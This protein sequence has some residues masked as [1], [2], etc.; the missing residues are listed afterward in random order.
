VCEIQFDLFHITNTVCVISWSLLYIL[1]DRP[2]CGFLSVCIILSLYVS[3]YV[4]M[5]RIYMPNNDDDDDDD[6]LS[7]ILCCNSPNKHILL[8]LLLFAV[9]V[10]G[11]VQVLWRC[12]VGAGDLRR[13][14]VH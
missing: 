1:C 7:S 4:Y 12:T 13:S 11:G 2:H 9:H 8:L 3:A 10:S 14:A 5:Y 6:D